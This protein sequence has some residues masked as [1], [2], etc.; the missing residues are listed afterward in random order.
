MPTAPFPILS[1]RALGT[2]TGAGVGFGHATGIVPAIRP[3]GQ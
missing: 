3:T 1:R 2:G